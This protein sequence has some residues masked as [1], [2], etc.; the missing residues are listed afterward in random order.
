[1]TITFEVNQ[2]QLEV[3]EELSYQCE[4]AGGE[5][6]HELQDLGKKIREAITKAMLGQRPRQS[7]THCQNCAKRFGKD[8]EVIDTAQQNG[9]YSRYVT[10]CRAC[11]DRAGNTVR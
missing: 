2:A 8:D 7:R 5:S 6:T 9:L 1:M 10:L 11:Y 3:L 4:D